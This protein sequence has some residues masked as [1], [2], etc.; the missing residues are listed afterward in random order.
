[1]TVEQAALRHRA[2]SAEQLIR[3]LAC[4]DMGGK[5]ARLAPLAGPGER[6]VVGMPIDLCRRR[7]FALRF[8]EFRQFGQGEAEFFGKH[9]DLFTRFRLLPQLKGGNRPGDRLL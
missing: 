6:R 8:F 5:P 4:I 3:V 1:M 2:F 7:P 9:L